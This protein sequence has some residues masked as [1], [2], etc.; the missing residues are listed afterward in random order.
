MVSISDIWVSFGGF[1]LLKGATFMVNQRDRIGL[2]GRNGA[3]KSTLLKILY[4][5]QKPTSGIVSGVSNVTM[6]Y[7]AQTMEVKDG[8][9]VMEEASLAFADVLN[10]EQ[11]IGQ[12]SKEV[13]DRTDYDSVEYGRLVAKLSDLNE[14]HALLGAAGLEGEV[15]K[16]LLGLGFERRDF[17]RQT[18]QFS[19][20]WRMRI[21]LAKILLQRPNLILL[22][23]PTN[24]LDI[25]SIQWLEDYLKDY[26][27]AVILISHD[28]AFLDNV[29]N[30]TVEIVLGK[31]HDYKVSYSQYVDLRK[32]RREQQL[33]AYRNQQKMI[34]DTEDFIERFRYKATK[35]VQVQSR[36]KQL[37]KVDRIE[38]DE[39]DN[40][41]LHI[42]F[43][44]APRSGQ[45]VM[46]ASNLTKAFGD[47][48]IF[49]EVSLK[50][51]RGEKVAFVGRNGEGKTT[52]SRIAV[53]DLDATV[54]YA[55]LGYNVSLGY[56]AQNQDDLMDGNM[57]VFDT[58]DQIAV[59]DIRTK[60]RDILGAFLF[61]G[62]DVDKKVKVLSG[63]ERSRLAMA[64]LMF[65]PYNLLILDE[66]TN[67]MDMLSKDILKEA[68]KKYD[69]TLIV[70]SHDRE[71]LDGLVNKL[72]EFRGG[73][74]K[75]HLGGIYDF[76]KRRKLESLK[77]LERKTTLAQ[78][79]Q[80]DKPLTEN[81]LSYA[82]RKEMDKVIRKV[83]SQ[84]SE[85][86]RQIEETEAEIAKIDVIMANPG[87]N[88]I[89][90]TDVDFF[91]RY[92]ELKTSVEDLMKEWE[93][94]SAEK[95][96]LEQERGIV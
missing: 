36:I 10:M 76:L 23:E 11:E 41:A 59:G 70:V 81:K 13:A 53:G 56:F 77:E 20:G 80:G 73:K 19:G 48:V 50:I 68:L 29:T 46:E 21:E 38:I 30:R 24:H 42:K 72:Y 64:K 3:G 45:I 1:D 85:C 94:L 91:K 58:I 33:S 35:S 79:Q 4:G 31:I 51:E 43:P 7:L 44:P 87:Q 15:E 37:D 28:R 40:T 88:A 74:V 55:K 66:P 82:E 18:S 8:R 9:T 61:R 92:H 32:E 34:E 2:V 6:G 26:T 93:S 47:H 65:Q 90:H 95:E 62:E 5:L 75:E 71:F 25:E 17:D 57:T 27:G 12:I 60:I 67:H 96:K 83:A 49:S 78:N 54:G 14:R 69:G 39:E 52:L 86:E 63:G 84:I 16:T 89:N 22:D